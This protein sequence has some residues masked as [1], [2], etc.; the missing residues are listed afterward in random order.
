MSD[1]LVSAAQPAAADLEPVL[2]NGQAARILMV[3]NYD[4]F[5]YNLVQYFGQLGC[6]VIERRNDDIGV[7]EAAGLGVHGIVV[8]PGPC[9]P[10]EAGQSVPL[11]SGL[12]G[13]VPILGVCLGHQALGAAFGASV[14][15]AGVLMH[16]KTS[17]IDHDG[18]GLFQ[19]LP[20]PLRVTRYHSLVVRNLPPELVVTATVHE[21]GE[22]VVMAMRHRDHPLYGVQFHPESILTQGG[23]RLL[24]N[25]L[26]DCQAR[27]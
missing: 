8:S 27:A 26:L 9:T 25:F 4:S 2:V 20:Q 15:R 13:R 18:Q 11:I 17:D 7:E 24:R 21:A 5:T 14:E 12:A 22:D 19:G 16:G 6:E 10:A 23:H 1:G 3:D